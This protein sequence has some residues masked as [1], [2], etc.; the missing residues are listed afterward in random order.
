MVRKLSVK[1]ERSSVMIL[2]LFLALF[3][4]L[5]ALDYF[6]IF[7]FTENFGEIVT[8]FGAFFVIVETGGF[9]AFKKKFKLLRMVGLVV[10]SVAGLTAILTI[11]NFGDAFVGFFD[12]FKGVL[13]LLL[14]AYVLIA[15]FTTQAQL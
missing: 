14:T 15:G 6:N 1:V 9:L 13:S 7:V 3:F 5:S 4:A 2:Y 12:P 10:A 11:L 8:L